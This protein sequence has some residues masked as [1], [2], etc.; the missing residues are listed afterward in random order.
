MYDLL[1]KSVANASKS[2]AN[3]SK[4]VANASKSVANASKSV[5]NAS[6]SVL[7]ASKSVMVVMVP[8]IWMMVEMT[9]VMSSDGVDG[10]DSDSGGVVYNLRSV[11][12]S[13]NGITFCC[14][15]RMAW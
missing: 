15:D 5:A 7:N 3:A 1:S 2:V 4:S 6:K 9:V 11:Q 8:V 14:L 13:Y 12:K 10:E